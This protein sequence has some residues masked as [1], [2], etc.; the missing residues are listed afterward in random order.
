MISYLYNPSSAP[1]FISDK[2]PARN[3]FDGKRGAG[4]TNVNIACDEFSSLTSRT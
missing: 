2:S 4:Q 1:I 3:I